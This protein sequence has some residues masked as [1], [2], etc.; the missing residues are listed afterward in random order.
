MMG[1]FHF[2]LRPFTLVLYSFVSLSFLFFVFVVSEKTN[3]QSDNPPPPANKATITSRPETI[4][5]SRGLPTQTT[6]RR[7]RRDP[8]PT[9]SARR[10]GVAAW[11]GASFSLS[12]LGVAVG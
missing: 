5:G 3:P 2:I 9:L 12:H 4:A 1:I 11:A 7:R 6:D 10:G 8:A